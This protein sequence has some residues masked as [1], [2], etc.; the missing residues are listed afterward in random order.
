MRGEFPDL[1]RFGIETRADHLLS[2]PRNYETEIWPKNFVR[3]N[4]IFDNVDLQYWYCDNALDKR[5]F[6]P[7]AAG[8][9][10]FPETK[11]EIP[12]G[13]VWP[14]LLLV[15][16]SSRKPEKMLNMHFRDLR[17]AADFFVKFSRRSKKAFKIGVG[18][19]GDGESYPKGELGALFLQG[20]SFSIG[21]KTIV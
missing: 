19:L 18:I 16:R 17:E 3:D 11:N 15:S 1:L 7:N 13:S 12:E 10:Y 4:R 20:Q 21:T 2:S 9:R 5:V 6:K 14:G 8:E